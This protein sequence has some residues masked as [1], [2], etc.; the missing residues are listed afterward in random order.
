MRV[1]SLLAITLAVVLS[2]SWL[3]IVLYPSVQDFMGANPFWNGVRDFGRRFDAEM[4]PGLDQL[5]PE[6]KGNVLVVIPYLP[7]QDGELK[8]LVDFVNG[9]G[10]LLVM[11]DY[12]YGNQVLGALGLDMEFVG[13][14]LLDPYLNYRNQWFP[15][16]VDLAPELKGAGIKELVLN[17]ATALITTNRSETLARSSDMS[18]IDT[19]GNAAWDKAEPKGPFTV[20]ARANVGSGTVIAVS[21]PS[22]LI[23]SMV[24]QGDNDKFLAQL[25]S[26]A[27]P[28]PQ[29]ALDASHLPKAPLDI[30]KDA[31]AMA[32][33]RLSLPYSQALLVGAVLTLSFIPVW[34]KGVEI[35]R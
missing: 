1:R 28:K 6:P 25:I 9:G 21:D 27:G 20:A 32:R 16:A 17:H 35:E 5:T 19:N 10:T 15:V 13:A 22:I 11:D 4:L 31:W 2:V 30:A 34:R 8:Q 7:Y 24:G 33:E 3:S 26:Q 12:G 23:N 18:F 14:T 29:V